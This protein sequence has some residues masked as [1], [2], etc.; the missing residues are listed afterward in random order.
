MTILWTSVYGLLVV[1]I[2]L[3]LALLMSC[4]STKIW[5]SIV[6][7]INTRIEAAGETLLQYSGT[8]AAIEALNA[9]W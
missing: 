3:L 1:E 7:T 6:A 2:G 8:K 9:N 5:C 4:I